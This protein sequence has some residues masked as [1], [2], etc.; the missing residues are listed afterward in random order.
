MNHVVENRVQTVPIGL[1][2]HSMVT[3]RAKFNQQKLERLATSLKNT[4]G[5]LE[6]LTVRPHL[7][8]GLT[9]YEVV[10]G[11]RRLRAAELAG[12]TDLPVEIRQLTDS[13]AK[14]LAL[15]D[16]LERERLSDLEQI[17]DLLC[18]EI[19]LDPAGVQRVLNK[20]HF[21][22]QKNKSLERILSGAEGGAFLAE[23]V[24]TIIKIFEEI[25]S[26][27]RNYLTNALP[28]LALPEDVLE[29][30]RHDILPSKT[31]AKQL[32]RV[33]SVIERANLMERLKTERWSSRTLEAEI[34][35]TLGEI[36]P[37]MVYSER[38][39]KITSRIEK[40]PALLDSIEDGLLALLGQLEL[41]VMNP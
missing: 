10:R 34:N 41:L 23:Q 21:C 4:N 32:A 33:E 7:E 27:W 25:G 31:I 40:H 5:P 36:K 29:G 2:R 3:P 11:E 13:E 9:V 14:R 6:P 37:C 22:Q 39:R 26:T 24:E 18:F 30:L 19:S 17:E 35:R 16:M 20:M 1:L 38:L 28:L 15:I 12:I 8:N